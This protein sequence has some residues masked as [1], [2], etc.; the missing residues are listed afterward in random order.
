MLGYPPTP[1]RPPGARRLTAR[2]AD[3]Q[4][5]GQPRGGGSPPPPTTPKTVAHPS[6]SHI[7]WRQPPWLPRLRPNIYVLGPPP[8]IVPIVDPPPPRRKKV[9]GNARS[10]TSRLQIGNMWSCGLVI[11]VMPWMVR[12][13]PCVCVMR[14]DCNWVLGFQCLHGAQIL[15]C[16]HCIGPRSSDQ[17]HELTWWL[18]FL[19]CVTGFT[20]SVPDGVSGGLKPPRPMRGACGAPDGQHLDDEM[21][22]SAVHCWPCALQW[23]VQRPVH[24]YVHVRGGVPRRFVTQ[25]PRPPELKG[26]H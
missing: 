26:G 20:A 17:D 3:P 6:G 4:G 21:A 13:C 10:A 15:R 9:V 8:T 2:L 7:G 1:P 19:C 12:Q 16:L 24:V 18:C 5:L 25:Q 14:N 11:I 23:G 22:K